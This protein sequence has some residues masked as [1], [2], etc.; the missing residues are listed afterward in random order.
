MT[1]STLKYRTQHKLRLSHMPW[2]YWRLKPSQREWAESWQAEVQHYLQSME[3]VII[4]GDCFI[5]PEAK[6]FAERGRP[7]IIHSGSFIGADAVLHGPIT[8]GENVGINHHVTMEGGS[9]GITI[10]D[11]CRIAAYCHLYAFNHGM[12]ADALISEQSVSSKGI[13][14]EEDVWL[15]AHVGVVDGVTIGAGSIV[16]MQS[17]VTKNIAASI[18]SAGNP[19]KK[20][21]ERK[22]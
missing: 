9:K 15:G 8:I 16:G 11:N 19:A 13:T 22:D 4:H 20:I 3:T 21:G 6:I 14:L 18:K 5:A 12:A 2:L 10:G 1:D 17:V 7:V